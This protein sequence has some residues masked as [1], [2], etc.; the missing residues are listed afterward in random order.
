MLLFLD[1][2][3]LHC[4]VAMSK[5]ISVEEVCCLAGA[6][7]PGLG[8]VLSLVHSYLPQILELCNLVARL[9]LLV[10]QL[11]RDHCPVGTLECVLVEVL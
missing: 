9:L 11:N 5:G 8:Y 2:N 10:V 3:Y 1:V 7:R 6:T 4:R